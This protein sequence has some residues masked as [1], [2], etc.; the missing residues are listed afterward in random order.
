M[1]PRGIRLFD[2]PE[3]A[4]NPKAVQ[5]RIDGKRKTKTFRTA[6]EQTE[7]AKQLAGSVREHG[8]GVLRLEPS[9]AL[10]WRAFKA[11]LGP[12]A[13]L[14]DVLAC[15]E[16]HRATVKPMQLAEA[17]AA[18]TEAKKLESIAES[19]LAHYRPVFDRFLA[20]FG[21]RDVASFTREELSQ[22]V[23][24]LDLAQ[25]SRKSHMS[26]IRSLFRWLRICRHIA[27]DPC[28]GMRR[29]KIVP[30]EIK[31]ISPEDGAT[32]FAVN[33]KQEVT[34]HRELCGRLALEAF[35]GIRYESVAKFQA[36]D[37]RWDLN[38]I[39]LPA[40]RIKTR[41][42]KFIQNLPSNLWAWLK[43]S[44]PATWLMTPRQYLQAKSLAFV[45]ANIPHPR[46][47]LRKC[48]ATYHLA[49]NGNAGHTAA[50]LCH[51]SLAKLVN[52]YNGIAS[53]ETGA[54]WFQILPPS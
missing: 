9:E 36:E 18:Y 16:K 4:T 23:G 6:E 24:K 51:T 8:A 14:D 43:W 7:F 17:I 20:S 19:T 54:K 21:G 35:A 11:R 34:D 38:G 47:C 22:W 46:N 49:A 42:R 53:A 31:L 33:S 26:R 32:L 52:D 29:I 5:W 28:E 40:D 27:E 15:W 2:L 13:T 10:E 44:D 30:K 45:R 50:M 25:Q 3:R 48:A 37:V 41:K 12:G 39:L 1:P